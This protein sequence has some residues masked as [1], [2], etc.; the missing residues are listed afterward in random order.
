[1]IETDEAPPLFAPYLEV[2]LAPTGGSFGE[3]LQ[4]L[5]LRRWLR[6]TFSAEVSPIFPDVDLAG[7]GRKRGLLQALVRLLDWHRIY[8]Y[9]PTA[10]EFLYRK[11]QNMP[12]L[13][14]EVHR[15]PVSVAPPSDPTE[16][17]SG[18]VWEQPFRA[19]APRGVGAD[20]VAEQPGAAGTGGLIA[21]IEHGWDLS[22]SRLQHPDLPNFTMM[23]GGEPSAPL[24]ADH[25]TRVLGILAA[26]RSWPKMDVEGLVPSATPLVLLGN[27]KRRNG[28]DIQ[29]TDTQLGAALSVLSEGDVV[30]VE[31]QTL[32]VTTGK[33]VPAEARATVF[34]G[35]QACIAAGITVVAAAGNGGQLLA[36][37]ADPGSVLV[38]GGKCTE[39]EA[40]VKWSRIDLTN[41]GPRINCFAEGQNV[42]TTAIDLLET[43]PDRYK[44]TTGFS[45]TSAAAAIIA[46]VAASVQGMARSLRGGPLTPEALRKLLSDPANGTSSDDSTPA[47]PQQIGVMPDLVKLAAAIPTLP[48]S[49]FL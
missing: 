15:V 29:T 25:G 45:G 9:D 48:S 46:G 26:L 10:T 31:A 38:A 37:R 35:I 28:H 24:Y 21:D 22:G 27:L 1:M 43:G 19:A 13:F 17:P 16:F 7:V 44:V 49:Y 8:L 18:G 33:L 36:S 34:A 2:R 20:L 47:G 4:A 3:R 6:N 32:S 12:N 42:P 5:P 40:T 23:L 41:Y 14:K 30:L 39:A 11:L